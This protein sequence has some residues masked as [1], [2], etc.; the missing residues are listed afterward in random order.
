MATAAELADAV[1]RAVRDPA[2]LASVGQE[3]RRSAL[4]QF[5]L[6]AMVAAYADAYRR[7]AAVPSLTRQSTT[8]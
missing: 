5:S 4:K 3:A 1:G 8:A 2:R 6:E 7:L